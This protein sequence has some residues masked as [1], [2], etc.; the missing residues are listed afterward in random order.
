MP[1]PVRLNVYDMYWLNEYSIPAGF[2]VFHAGV[3]VFGVEYAFGGHQFP[4]SGVFTN[5]PQ[6]D[7]ELG[8]SFKFRESI[9]LGDTA[10]SKRSVEKLVK[11][12]GE[13]YRGDSYHLISKN[14][15]HF[16]AHLA[17]EL[18]GT[19]IPNWVNR[20]ASLSGS[21]PFLQK[22]I[23][24]EWLTP[25]ALEQSLEQS[26]EISNGTTV[27]MNYPSHSIDKAEDALQFCN[28]LNETGQGTKPVQVSSTHDV[29]SAT[30]GVLTSNGS[31]SGWFRRTSTVQSAPNSARNPTTP[32]PLARLWNSIKNIASDDQVSSKSSRSNQK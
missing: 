30:N 27:T 5:Q 29:V 32:P 1:E 9:Y 14:C 11:S 2:G 10:L 3:E 22:W 24:L 15:N 16:A 23:P 25:I 18:T 8:E 28:G 31:S 13:E 7:Q 4:F 21:I 26:G 6:D 20:L 17:K 19:E 12:L